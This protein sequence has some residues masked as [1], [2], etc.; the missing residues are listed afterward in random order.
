MAVLEIPTSLPV[1]NLSLSS[2]NLFLRCPDKWR[3]RYI[4]NEYEGPATPAM[5]LG[6]AV[7]AAEGAAYQTQIDTGQR[8][9]S[10]LVQD[11]FADEWLERTEREEI[12]WGA[13][14][15]G[16][17]KDTGVAAVKAYDLHIAPGVTPLYVEREF[18]LGFEGVDWGLAG[19]FDVEDDDETVRDLK[20][21]G[22]KMTAVDADTDLQPTA[23]LLARR[24]EGRPASGFVFD[25]M[26]KTKTPYAEIVSTDRTDAQLD[27]F[28][29]RL[30]GVAAEISWRVET[31]NWAYSAPGNFLCSERMCGYWHRCPGGG[32]R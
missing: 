17:L 13:D 4:D 10:E 23:Y 21:R 7:G 15:P 1:A 5:V 19:F 6:S 11:A 2:V 30:Y 31:G 12:A 22:R 29:H 14:K 26:V 9:T 28:T 25:T 3:R 20:V 24:A 18:R 27:A 16:L 32:L 8:P